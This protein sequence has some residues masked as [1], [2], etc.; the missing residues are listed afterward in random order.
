MAKSNKNEQKPTLLEASGLTPQQE[1][2][3]ILLASGENYTTVAEKLGINRGTLYEWQKDTAFKCFYNR[4]CKDFQDEITNGVMSLHKTALD[5]VRILLLE[6]ND[7]TRL[8]AAFWVLDKVAS[9]QVGQADLIEAV[10]DECTLN[11]GDEIKIETFDREKYDELMA[12]YG[13]E[14]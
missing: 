13:Y 4:Q 5:T 11:W 10:K 2:A 1:R 3:C 9:M 14:Q 8:K 7:N 12:R 6:G